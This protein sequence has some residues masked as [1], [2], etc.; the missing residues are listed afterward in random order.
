MS[1]RA[2]PVK[3]KFLALVMLAS[4]VAVSSTSAFA[5]I[6]KRTHY[7]SSNSMNVIKRHNHFDRAA[8]IAGL[9]Q[10][11]GIAGNQS[12]HDASQQTHVSPS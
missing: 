6:H 5:Q 8:G 3:F 12:K 1:L 9:S 11:G 2:S 4:A 10:R 7:R